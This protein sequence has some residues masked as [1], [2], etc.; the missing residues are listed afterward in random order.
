MTCGADHPWE[1][2]LSNLPTYPSPGKETA[3][4]TPGLS[5]PDR[6]LLAAG[7]RITWAQSVAPVS[8]VS[9]PEMYP[10]GL[11]FCNADGTPR[12]LPENK[13]LCLTSPFVP[14]DRGTREVANGHA[15]SICNATTNN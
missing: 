8:A 3:R 12:R 4:Q 11:L 13:S 14:N 10:R 9:S 1:A 2:L 15:Y 6:R 5:S 7:C